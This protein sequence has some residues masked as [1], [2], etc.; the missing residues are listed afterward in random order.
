MNTPQEVKDICQYLESHG[1]WAEDDA[2]VIIVREFRK[3]VD[4]F[5]GKFSTEIQRVEIRDWPHAMRFVL[6]RK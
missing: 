1:Y 5:S 6:A 4:L 3:M 2:G